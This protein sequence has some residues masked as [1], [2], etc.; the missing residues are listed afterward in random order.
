MCGPD[1]DAQVPCHDPRVDLMSGTQ[2]GPGWWRGSDGRWYPPQPHPGVSTPGTLKGPEDTHPEKGARSRAFREWVR[3]TGPSSSITS[4]SLKPGPSSVTTNPVITTSA[5]L[6]Q[7]LLPAQALGTTA[8]VNT[9]STD[10]SQIIGICGAP[11]PSGAQ[12]TAFELLQDSQT[13]Q[14]LLEIIIDWSTAADEV[15][16]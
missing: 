1:R 5:Q 3:P 4:T 12:V 10:L 16:L 14:N 2:P 13:N 6:T 15:L 7:A 9:K 8:T 11:L